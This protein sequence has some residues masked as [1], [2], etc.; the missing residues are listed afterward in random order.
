[1]PSAL[2]ARGVAPEPPQR[3]IP[4]APLLEVAVARLKAG[5]TSSLL[6]A[7]YS[8]F[9]RLFDRFVRLKTPGARTK[10]EPTLGVPVPVLCAGAV[11]ARR[12]SEAKL[13][14]A[15]AHSVR[16]VS[17]VDCLCCERNSC[18]FSQG[19]GR[20]AQS[21][22]AEGRR[23]WRVV[24]R[25]QVAGAGAALLGCGEACSERVFWR[26]Q[27]IICVAGVPVLSFLCCR[28]CVVFH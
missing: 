5:P 2:P 12:R 3:P 25:V 18:P 8:S 28:S 10:A 24:L 22:R 17:D 6:A 27:E 21:V 11:P 1:M 16:A 9:M 4:D 20:V 26:G 13:G 19:A 23:P 14:Q 15:E 7:T